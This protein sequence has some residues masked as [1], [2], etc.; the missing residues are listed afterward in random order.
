[1]YMKDLYKKEATNFK[2]ECDDQLESE[3]AATDLMVQRHTKERDQTQKDLITKGETEIQ[4][5]K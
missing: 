3:K 5:E 1:M 2:K 4:K